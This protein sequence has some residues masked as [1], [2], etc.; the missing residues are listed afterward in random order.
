M[1]DGGSLILGTNNQSR[2]Q[3]R[4]IRNRGNGPAFGV[5]GTSCPQTAV[6]GWGSS[7]TGVLGDSGSGD[8]VQGF[9]TSGRG[10]YG[11][12]V[13]PNPAVQGHGQQHG[14]WGSSES[15]GWGVIGVAG[16]DPTNP[17]PYSYAG[18][19]FG[20]TW[21]YG[22]LVVGGDVQINGAL[23]VWGSPKSSVVGHPDGSHRLLYTMESP[24]EDF[25]T[26]NLSRGSVKVRLDRDFAAVVRTRGY[27][28][29]L[30]PEGKSNGLYVSRKKRTGFEVREQQSGKSSI[31]FSYRVVARRK[32]IH[33]TRLPKVKPP[34][35]AKPP[36]LPRKKLP[37]E[38][39]SK[40]TAR[41][42]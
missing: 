10:V 28:V 17:D 25:G 4:I 27:H 8:G 3:T 11:E 34:E 26:A 39:S 20:R 21:V 13:G 40:P 1:A 35:V 42:L 14:I 9:S 2:N 32:D 7:G 24:F 16:P 5:D 6:V 41:H 37:R 29:F 22:L 36:K 33:G 12:S 30:T 23:K 15:P 31:R 38:A 19:F 18:A